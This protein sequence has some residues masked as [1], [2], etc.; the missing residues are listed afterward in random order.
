MIQSKA[1][2]SL[3][4]SSGKNVSQFTLLHPDYYNNIQT[5]SKSVIS[6]HYLLVSMAKMI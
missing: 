2:Y 1:R 5:L 4:D 6:Q 3:Y